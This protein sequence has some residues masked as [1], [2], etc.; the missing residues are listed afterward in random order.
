[1]ESQHGRCAFCG[2]NITGKGKH[3]LDHIQP[4]ALGGSHTIENLQYL[5]P[6][7]NMRKSAKPPEIAMREVGLLPLL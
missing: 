5:C 1:M 7:C 2:K 4:L 3:H 6:A